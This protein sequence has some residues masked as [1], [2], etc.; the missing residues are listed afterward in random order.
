MKLSGR[1]GDTVDGR[2]TRAVLNRIM[3]VGQPVQAALLDE[4]REYLAP[5][6]IGLNVDVDGVWFHDYTSLAGQSVS[7]PVTVTQPAIP[8]LTGQLNGDLLREYMWQANVA[9]KRASKHAFV[10]SVRQSRDIVMRWVGEDSEGQCVLG[11]NTDETRARAAEYQ[12]AAHKR[13]FRVRFSLV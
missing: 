7:V 3:Q 5:Y 10:E 13:G 8:G 1:R 12:A 2:L 9:E 11:P 6:G 4:Y